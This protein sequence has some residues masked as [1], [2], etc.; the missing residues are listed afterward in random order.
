MAVVLAAAAAAVAVAFATSRG[1]APDLPGPE[2]S[3]PSPAPAPRPAPA[4][5]GQDALEALTAPLRHG[6][7]A[8]ARAVAARRIAMAGP[9]AASAAGAVIEALRIETDAV[10]RREMVAALE[11]LRVAES[12]AVLDRVARGDP[13]PR[14]RADAVT[15]PGQVAVPEPAALVAALDAEA[16]D[17]VQAEWLRLL[18]R[19]DGPMVDAR[20]VAAARQA[21]GARARG[22]ALLGLGSRLGEAGSDAWEAVRHA[23]ESD[24]DSEVRAAAAMV[25]V[26]AGGDAGRA[27]ASEARERERDPRA[28]A[29]MDELLGPAPEGDPEQPGDR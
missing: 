9:P 23:L 26:H 2:P 16:D 24:H 22:R 7:D 17:L 6:T 8:E 20:L 4:P 5:L 13:D 27:H 29:L 21:P 15:A 14:V 12:A 1:R 11:A 18:A 25:L 28:R 3:P 19:R 10:A